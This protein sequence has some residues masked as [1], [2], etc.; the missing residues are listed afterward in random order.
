MISKNY[1]VLIKTP[2]YFKLLL[3]KELYNQLL[4]D[5]PVIYVGL[6]RE[7]HGSIFR[8]AI[9]R[10]LEPLDDRTDPRIR[11]DGPVG[12]ILMVKKKVIHENVVTLF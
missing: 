1:F 6:D 4:V 7:D 9:G 10:G 5:P 2:F 8:I 3:I 12:R 11:L